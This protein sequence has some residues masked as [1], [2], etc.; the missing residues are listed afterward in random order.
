MEIK[1]GDLIFYNKKSII[2]KLINKFQRF[3]G[4]PKTF[5]S[6][7]GGFI[8]S[9]SILNVDMNTSIVDKSS[10]KNKNVKIYR[11]NN[12]NDTQRNEIILFAI[13]YKNRSYGYFKLI[14]H[15][16]DWVLN[17][18]TNKEIFFF[19]QL[20]MFNR[21]PICSWVWAF[22]YNK[23]GYNFGMDPKFANPDNMHDFIIN[24]VDWIL[25]YDSESQ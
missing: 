1:K 19:R 6:H 23:I 22:A 13:D 11:N 3:R 25:I 10:I 5:A 4:E 21:Y 16:L 7:V 24:S 12:I 2:G 9:N 14:T 18:I 20:N 17:R 8:S 15:F